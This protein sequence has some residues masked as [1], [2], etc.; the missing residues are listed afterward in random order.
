MGFF[1]GGRG[2]G[3]FFGGGGGGFALD[4]ISG[5][6]VWVRSDDGVYE[7]STKTTLATDDDDP[8]GAQEDL[9]GNGNDV[10]QATAADRPT[11]KTNILGT[12]PVVRGDGTGHSLQCAAFDSPISQPLTLFF[13]GRVVDDGDILVDSADSTDRCMLWCNV[14]EFAAWAGSNHN[15]TL[16]DDDHHCFI[17]VFNGA[18]SIFRIDGY[19]K[20][21]NPGT[22]SLDGLTIGA[23]YDQSEKYLNGDEAEVGVWDGE[24]SSDDIDDL[25][26]YAASEWGITLVDELELYRTSDIN[27][28]SYRNNALVTTSVDGT[29]YQAHAFWNMDGQAVIQVRNDSGGSFGDWTSYVYDGTNSLPDISP[30]N[31]SDHRAIMLGF[32]KDG[33]LHVAYDHHGNDLHYRKASN[34]IDSFDGSLSSESSMLGTNE[35]NVSYV[36]FFNAPQDGT[37]YCMFRNGP[38]TD[39][40]IY[41]YEYDESTGWAAATGTGTNGLLLENNANCDTAYFYRPGFDADFPNSGYMHFAWH[42]RNDGTDGDSNRDVCYARWD[43]TSFEQSDGTGQTTPITEANDEVVDS[44]AVSNGLGSTSSVSSDDNGYPHIVYIKNNGDATP[45]AQ[46]YHV[47]HNGTAWQSPAELTSQS[48]VSSSGDP[49]N[50]EWRSPTI[51]IN[52]TDGHAY[53]FYTLL[54]KTGIYVLDSTDYSSWTET[55]VDASETGQWSPTF[56]PWQWV[57]NGKFYLP[58]QPFYGAVHLNFEIVEYTPS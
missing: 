58:V 45:H 54:T 40:Y 8:V 22:N 10:L 35:D 12:K 56:D 55:Q 41:F 34:A 26:S 46:V 23:K 3:G 50:Y 14:D 5:L 17:V 18:S 27:G 19:E 4:G 31:N 24:L 15:H 16:R 57:N 1:G 43:G 39:G 21:I 51:A 32:D 49:E 28:R 42:W 30:T 2:M 13:V 20:S 37:L 48:T 38:A 52:Q 47:W 11:L 9:S 53:V 25:E 29:E 36:Q 44:V 6:V 7:E 33:Y